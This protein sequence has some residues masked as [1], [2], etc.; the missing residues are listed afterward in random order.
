[1]TMEDLA[2]GIAHRSESRDDPR[3]AMLAVIARPQLRL[4][5]ERAAAG[6]TTRRR[7][8]AVP[9][10]GVVGCPRDDDTIELEPS[11]P[12]LLPFAV[13]Q[14][15]DL[16]SRPRVGRGVGPGEIAVAAL[17]RAG[18]AFDA[19]DVG[20][21]GASLRDGGLDDAWIERLLE[22]L[23][24]RPLAWRVTSCWA[25]E[26]DVLHDGELTVFDGGLAG[27]VRATRRDGPPPRIELD[28]MT[29]REAWRR[30]VRLFPFAPGR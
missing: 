23:R 21:A 19:G 30:L 4:L 14:F 15:V 29:S 17:A 22:V 12:I 25:D 1:M 18:A 3:T 5:V 16:G 7:I 10:L 24:E 8:W 9:E 28:A 26:R 27:Y 11:E 2:E 13:A 6:V 20:G